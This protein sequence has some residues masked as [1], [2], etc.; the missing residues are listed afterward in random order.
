MR[1]WVVIPALA[2]CGGGVAVCLQHAPLVVGGVACL[3]ASLGAA[4]RGVAGTSVAATEGAVAGTMLGVGGVL[5]SPSLQ[6]HSGRLAAAG[7]AATFAV[8]ALA[9][10]RNHHRAS[11]VISAAAF[12]ASALDP[13]YV[14]L[15]AIAGFYVA[16]TPQHTTRRWIHGLPI[17]GGIATAAVAAMA[18]CWPGSSVW[19]TWSGLAADT[20]TAGEVLERVGNALGPIA[21]CVGAMGLV[22]CVV[23][24]RFAG[25]AVVSITAMSAIAA[26]SSAEV[27][28][29]VPLMAGVA[30]GVAIWRFATTL[31][32]ATGQTFV[33]A[34]AGF[35]IVAASAWPWAVAM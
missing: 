9:R 13:V 2:V 10:A 30:V 35:V 20:A 32:N 33:G 12:L 6:L 17:A 14:P 22:L 24:D 16:A 18:I 34:T 26:L 7:A 1:S 29:A 21:A 11:A 31:D 23:R 28:L 27:P 15:L 3:A 25:V 19:R 8:Y 4:I 5:C